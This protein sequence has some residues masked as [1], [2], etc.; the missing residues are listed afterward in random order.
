MSFF[1]F[2]A[3]LAHN[4][5]VRKEIDHLVQ[6]R[7][8]FNATITRF[9][10]KISANRRVIGE[11]TESAILAFDQRDEAQNKMAALQ[12]RN[13]KEAMQ[14]T[15]ELKELQRLLDHDERLKDFLFHKSND[16]AF[17]ADFDEEERDRERKEAQAKDNE[18]T[19]HFREAFER[20]KQFAAK[21]ASMDR[22]VADFI[23]V[24]DQNFALFN[25]VTEMNNQVEGLQESIAKLRTDI[26][27]AKGRGDEQ[28]RHQKE[29]LNS[30]ERRVALSVRE[31]DTAE[32]KL[33]LM[34]GVLSKLK[35][36]V[37]DLHL[38]CQIGSTPVLSLL[39]GQ[40]ETKDTSQ[41][42]FVNE[43]NI[44]M[45]LDIINEKSVELK[46]IAQFCDSQLK[47]KGDKKSDY[48]AYS[49]FLDDKKKK[50]KK[51]PSCAALLGRAEE[52]EDSSDASEAVNIA[53]FEMSALKSRAFK[54]TKKDREEA[55]KEYEGNMHME[56]K[57][58][59]RRKSNESSNKKQK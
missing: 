34:E 15:A 7:A 28:E 59:K 36:G 55:L 26:R 44:I 25:Y 53:P 38:S 5:A 10:K 56:E 24:E 49:S 9:Q 8:R 32:A 22:I 52:E 14:Y 40:P 18:T 19:A 6:E 39:G 50:V 12:D 1:R 51:L 11:I 21:D 42:P 35:S 20:I 43:R 17:A 4:G 3:T 33:D 30:M 2:N 45:Y 41:K 48:F 13:D 29:Q 58:G 47:L 27:L 31:A 57:L 37:E 46:G 23:K 16:R 54:L